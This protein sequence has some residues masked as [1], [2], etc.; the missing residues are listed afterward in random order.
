MDVKD[1]LENHLGNIETSDLALHIYLTPLPAYGT[2]FGCSQ[3]L[4]P[5]S[6]F[7]EDRT[8]LEAQSLILVDRRYTVN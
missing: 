2:S 3:E 4:V 1:A 7:V 8:E 5:V 6:P